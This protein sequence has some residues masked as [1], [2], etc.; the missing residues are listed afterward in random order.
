MKK[1][2]A[3]ILAATMTAGMAISAFALVPAPTA[4]S[5]T[6]VTPENT[7]FALE[8]K[9]FLN[10]LEVAEGQT[11][12]GGDKIYY[13][14]LVANEEGNEFS[15]ANRSSEI[16]GL[17]VKLENGVGS[18]YIKNTEIVRQSVGAVNSNPADDQKIYCVEVT[19]GDYFGTTDAQL[20]F[21]LSLRTRSTEYSSK[22]QD[23]NAPM[24]FTLGK[25]P[26]KLSTDSP[27][28]KKFRNGTLT[29]SVDDN[30]GSVRLDEMADGSEIKEIILEGKKAPVSFEVR[31]SGQ[32]DLYLSVNQ[33]PN[34]AVT[35]ANEE[36]TLSFV[37]FP[38]RPEFD[39]TGTAKFIVPDSEKEY[40]LYEIANGK[41]VKTNAKYNDSDECFEL[42]TR[43]LGS[44]VLSDR[45]LND[46]VVPEDNKNEK[47]AEKPADKPNGDKVVG[48]GAIA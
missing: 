4:E 17:K 45:E 20:E 46:V 24:S 31:A 21:D 37:N 1:L 3:T 22:D 27:I 29:L 2:L 14:I 18:K 28:V 13:P 40:F 25:E 5:A 19:V 12:K 11:L 9:A 8:N 33:D 48:T 16:E 39:F 15:Y 26:E 36:A 30:T 43:V 44:Y 32:K 42:R 35:L 23:G 10:N 7:D 41:L 34:K 38:G 47:P 6:G